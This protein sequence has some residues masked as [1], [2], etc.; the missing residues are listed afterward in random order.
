MG[1]FGVPSDLVER[2]PDVRRAEQL[3][4]SQTARIGV[5]ETRR[6]PSL[7][8]SA[9]LGGSVTNTINTALV[10]IGAGLL[11]P[12]FD[13]GRSRQG[14]AAEIAR[15]QQLLAQYRQSILSAF[16]KVEDALAAVGPQGRHPP[17]CRL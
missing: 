15:T 8:L 12:L 2:R 11:G 16:R 4:A 17:L 13:A 6:F 7:T 14:V 3:L 5:A 9:D 10:T 1:I